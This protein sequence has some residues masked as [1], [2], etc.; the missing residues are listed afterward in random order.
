MLTFHLFCLKITY[1]T[2][3]IVALQ[4]TEFRYQVLPAQLE[5]PRIDEIESKYLLNLK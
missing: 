5:F 3:L 4:K 1:Y 2:G